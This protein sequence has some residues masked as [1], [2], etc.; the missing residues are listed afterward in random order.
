MTCPLDTCKCQRYEHRY[1]EMVFL[2]IVRKCLVYTHHIIFRQSFLSQVLCR[3][4]HSTLE[5]LEASKVHAKE[6]LAYGC[7]RF[8]STLLQRGPIYNERALR[9][10]KTCLRQPVVPQHQMGLVTHSER[11]RRIQGIQYPNE[12]RTTLILSRMTIVEDD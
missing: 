8:P 9:L 12:Q 11:S 4:C 6:K 5:V 7:R 2:F 10:D 3:L 1:N